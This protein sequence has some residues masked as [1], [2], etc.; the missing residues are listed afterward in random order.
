MVTVKDLETP[1]AI[2]K[3]PMKAIIAMEI[4]LTEEIDLSGK[5]EEQAIYTGAMKTR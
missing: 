2:L 5:N 4:T 3:E 1:T